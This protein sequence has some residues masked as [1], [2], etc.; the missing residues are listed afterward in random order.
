MNFSHMWNSN[1][2]WYFENGIFFNLRL[3]SHGYGRHQDI[4]SDPRFSIIN[5]P[6][7]AEQGKGGNFMEYKNKFL[8]RRYKVIECWV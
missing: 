2:Q 1:I 8:Q 6:F 3:L 4:Q 5:E 7:K